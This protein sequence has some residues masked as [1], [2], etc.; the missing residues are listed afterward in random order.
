MVTSSVAG[1]PIGMDAEKL[2]ADL[3]YYFQGHGTSFSGMGTNKNCRRDT[4]K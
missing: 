2:G 1:F 4:Y 3:Q